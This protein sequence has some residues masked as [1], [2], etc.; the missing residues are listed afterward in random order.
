MDEGEAV[1]SSPKEDLLVY[2]PVRSSSGE[3][4]SCRTRLRTPAGSPLGWSGGSRGAMRREWGLGLGYARRP[5]FPGDSLLVPQ[6]RNPTPDPAI[7]TLLH[8]PLLGRDLLPTHQ[9]T[10]RDGICP[11]LSFSSALRCVGAPRSHTS[12][13]IQPGLPS[14]PFTLSHFCTSRRHSRPHIH[15][16]GACPPLSSSPRRPPSP[17]STTL[18]HGPAAVTALTTTCPAPAAPP[19]AKKPAPGR[20]TP[21]MRPYQPGRRYALFGHTIV[22][23]RL[24]E[25]GHAQ[26]TGPESLNAVLRAR[27]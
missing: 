20:S 26:C 15:L 9:I 10:E 8:N 4:R 25:D 23:R 16:F 18:C 17:R 1:A 27:A 6:N 7:R 12:R 11:R 2:C 19:H 3:G 13:C 21:R 24:G 14:V 5:S 22:W